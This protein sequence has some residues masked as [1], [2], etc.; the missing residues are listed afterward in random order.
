MEEKAKAKAKAMRLYG[1]RPKMGRSPIV[2]SDPSRPRRVRT[3]ERNERSIRNPEPRGRLCVGVFFFFF[4]A[5]VSDCSS[6]LKNRLIRQ[7]G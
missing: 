4:R 1:P 7:T 2:L 3:E 6:G 5:I